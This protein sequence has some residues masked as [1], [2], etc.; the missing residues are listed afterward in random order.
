VFSFGDAVRHGFSRH[1]VAR[2]V[3]TGSWTRLQSGWYAPT[4]V[5]EGLPPRDQH[6]ARVLALLACR[7][8]TNVASHLSAA[9]VLGWPLPLDGAGPPTV[10]APTASC[11]T[12]RRDGFVVQVARLAGQDAGTV[13]AD[14][15][16]ERFAI[17]CTRPDR[18]AADLLRHL[19]V[20]DSVAIVDQALRGG[21]LAWDA[22]LRV[23]R[24]QEGWP[25][26][27]RARRAAE[28]V[29]PRRES[30]LESYSFC[31]LAMG[32]LPVP[33]PQVEVHD[34]KGRFVARLDGWWDDACV[35][36]E[37]DGGAKYLAGIGKVSDD[38]DTAADEITRHVRRSLLRQND[39]QHRLEDLGVLVVRWGTSDIVRRPQV[40]LARAGAARA[41]RDRTAFTGRLVRPQPWRL[42]SY[43]ARSESWPPEFGSQGAMRT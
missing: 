18:T 28:L 36:L 38:V 32:G 41:Q 42:D 17:R 21:D 9:A 33:E 13:Y 29:D 1:Q 3:T 26:A 6:L 11:P 2:R 30:W 10:T 34:A 31:T 7:P 39:R 25:Y 37:A 8:D 35:A 22:V 40:V 24:N 19:P 5:L 4:V 20:A 23:V 16:T 15:G 43:S 12:R 14:V 27:S